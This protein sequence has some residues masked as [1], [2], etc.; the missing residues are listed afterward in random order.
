[1][2]PEGSDRP[3]GSGGLGAGKFEALEQP[4][5]MVMIMKLP[6]AR[7]QM[8]HV[9]KIILGAALTIGFISGTALASLANATAA[10]AGQKEPTAIS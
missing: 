3:C 5:E 8:H 6:A 4:G 2:L 10:G 1:M 9:S 7:A